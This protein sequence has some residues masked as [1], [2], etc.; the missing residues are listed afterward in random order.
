[1]ETTWSLT[2]PWNPKNHWMSPSL[3]RPLWAES[4][5]NENSWQESSQSG[6][7]WV[8]FIW[9]P[10]DLMVDGRLYLWDEN[11]PMKRLRIFLKWIELWDY[12]ITRSGLYATHLSGVLN[13][14]VFDFVW[15]LRQMS[16]LLLACVNGKDADFESK[17]QTVFLVLPRSIQNHVI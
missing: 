7:S 6:R 1:M 4:S 10:S 17:K 5:S 9:F 3:N 11:F 2:G 14:D 13:R 16:H 15:T 12:I 8:I